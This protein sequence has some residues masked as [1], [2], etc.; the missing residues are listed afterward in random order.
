[1]LGALE[2]CFQKELFYIL[3]AV[4]MAVPN[5]PGPRTLLCLKQSKHHRCERSRPLKKVSEPLRLSVL[6]GGYSVF[7][8]WERGCEG[9][10]AWAVCLV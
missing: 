3:A 1:M 8:A 6:C 10:S 9:S 2:W 7:P 4:G 5:W